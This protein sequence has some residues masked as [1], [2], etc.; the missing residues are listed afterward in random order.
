MN[1][2]LSTGDINSRTE[3]YD[4]KSVN[5]INAVGGVDSDLTPGDTC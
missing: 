1:I 3:P 2:S 5:Y 4:P